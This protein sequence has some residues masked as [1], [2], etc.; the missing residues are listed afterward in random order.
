MDIRKTAFFIY[1]IFL[2]LHVQL[3]DA[4]EVTSLL[5]L[6]G[7]VV[8]RE[9][10]NPIPNVTI[11]NASLESAALADSTGFFSMMVSPGDTLIF[12]AMLYQQEVYMVPKGYRGG[13]FAIIEAMQKDKVLLEEVTVRAFPSQQ[14]FERVF[15]SIDPGNITE[16]T[17]VL[18]EHLD[19]ISEDPTNMQQYILDYY[20]HYVTYV[21]TKDAPPNNFLNP[22]KWAEFIRNWREG[23]FTEDAVENLPGFPDPDPNE[24]GEDRELPEPVLVDPE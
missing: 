3:A 1:T 2:F 22:D 16:K 14:Q 6:S 18:D 24:R 15:L 12:E 7:M 20:N 17:V 11:K 9:T 19:D 10:L 13:R 5:P 8:D 4:Q 21:I 23:V